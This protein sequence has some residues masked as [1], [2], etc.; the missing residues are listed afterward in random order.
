MVRVTCADCDALRSA[1]YRTATLLLEPYSD[2]AKE[3]MQRDR[4][5][6][7][8]VKALAAYREH[9]ATC[10]QKRA[11]NVESVNR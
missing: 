10:E 6:V 1:W 2:E 7:E 9:T 8:Y 4:R 3:Q 11:T 5:N